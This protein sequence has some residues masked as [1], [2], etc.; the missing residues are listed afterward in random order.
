MGLVGLPNVGKSSLFNSLT[1]S[2]V[3]SENYPFCTIEPSESRV[4]I[5]DKR[6]S[7]L[8]EF[9]NPKNIVP[10]FLS[11]IDIAGLVK[12]ASK[13]EGLGNAFLSNIR[14]VDG[15]F[16]LVRGFEDDSIAH[17]EGN[18]D[19][20][21]DVEIIQ[22]E[23][24]LKDLEFVEKY[25]S[26]N[27]NIK[28][29]KSLTP[30]EKDKKEA[31]ETML[32]VYDLICKNDKDVRQGVWSDRE[33]EFLNS[34]NLLTSKPVVYLMNMSEC[35]YAKKGNKYLKNLQDWMYNQNIK[36]QIIP[37]SGILEENLAICENKTEQEDYLKEVQEKYNVEAIHSALPLIADSGYKTLDL[38]HC[39][40]FLI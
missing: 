13:G 8:T 9:Y 3:P 7:W 33:I 16:H 31:Y 23:L 40:Y 36:D 11:V 2:E 35:D 37:F 10:A 12:G 24:R 21:R 4:E 25:L 29:G 22:T 14:A 38:H 17:V 34:W 30:A 28:P 32:K 15:I 39:K 26:S 6:F 20:V 18:I 19:P 27:K 5:K 1:N